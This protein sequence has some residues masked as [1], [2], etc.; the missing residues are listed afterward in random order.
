MGLKDASIGAVAL[1]LLAFGCELIAPTDRTEIDA[2]SQGG[3]DAGSSSS[4]SSSGS[5]ECLLPLDC[6]GKD[7]DCIVRTCDQGTCGKAKLP[8]GTPTKNQVAGDCQRAVC[9]GKGTEVLIVDEEDVPID[10]D[11]CTEDVCTASVP[12][13]PPSGAGAPCDADGGNVCNGQ[14]ACVECVAEADCPL[15]SQCVNNVCQ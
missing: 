15:G 5:V 9:D 12:S 13:N 4:G 14:G 10:V 3:A 8:L 7:E 6:P 2:G 1:A 11:P